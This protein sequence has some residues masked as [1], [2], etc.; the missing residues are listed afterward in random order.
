MVDEACHWDEH[1]KFVN[2][3]TRLCGQAYFLYRSCDRSQ[4]SNYTRL[5]EQLT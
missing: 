4:Q 3:V 1:T 2:L 5:I